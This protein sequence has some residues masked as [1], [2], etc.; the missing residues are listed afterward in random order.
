MPRSPEVPGDPAVERFL[1]GD[2]ET[3]AEA[4]RITQA[5][6]AFRGFYVP[7]QDR[8]DLVQESMM[9]L[10]RHLS[11]PERPRPRSF[12]AFVRALAYRRCVDWM[13]AMPRGREPLGETLPAAEDSAEGELLSTE[14]RRLGRRALALLSESCRDLIRRYAAE[15][16]SFRQIAEEDGRLEKTV[17]NQLYKCLDRARVLLRRLTRGDRLGLRPAEDQP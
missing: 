14:K 11:D 2:V 5:A 6:V 10:L 4:L 15:E 12:E 17:R 13:R 9:Q 7:P 8:V 1:A 3:V 16:A